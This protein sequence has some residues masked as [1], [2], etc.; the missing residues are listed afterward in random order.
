MEVVD[1][2]PRYLKEKDLPWGIFILAPIGDIQFGSPGT[3]LE[4]LRKHIRYCEGIGANYIGMGDYV[5][6]MSPSN[7]RSYRA[8]ALYDTT[9]GSIEKYH[10]DHL[11]KL[12]EILEPTRGKWLGLLEGHHYMELSHGGTTDTELAK[13]LEA[14]YL[15]TCAVIRLRF[16]E[17]S[18]AIDYLVYAHHGIG[19]GTDPLAKLIKVA[20]GFPQV[21]LFLQGHNT[22]VDARPLDSIEFYGAKGGLKM[23]EKKVLFVAT[24]GFMRGY[25]QSS[26]EGVYGRPQGSYVEKAMM[27]PT[28]LGAPVIDITPRHFT[29]YNDLE[30]HASV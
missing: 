29:E 12:K 1:F 19:G 30:V 11:E 7:R 13:F 3:D 25:Q 26:R 23:R 16:R 27:R 5:D 28:T 6:M 14:P 17:P 18:R 10:L 20:P 8:A 22:Q 15:G 4:K 2:N 9:L 21:D 24:G